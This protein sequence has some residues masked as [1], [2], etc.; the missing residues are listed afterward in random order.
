MIN[1]KEHIHL[2]N[3]MIHYKNQMLNC[4]LYWAHSIKSL[5]SEIILM[6]KYALWE[7]PLWSL[8]ISEGL[9]LLWHW[10]FDRHFLPLF[11]NLVVLLKCLSPKRLQ[12]L[13]HSDL[14]ICFFGKKKG[15][16]SVPYFWVQSGWLS[17]FRFLG[18]ICYSCVWYL[19]PSSSNSPIQ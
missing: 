14:T 3:D 15:A 19:M 4:F 7:Q 9:F 1:G 17:L 2:W 18:K 16:F 12:S 13:G 8:K 6:V 5:H 10:R 11:F